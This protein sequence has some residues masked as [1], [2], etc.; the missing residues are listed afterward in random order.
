[1]DS[2]AGTWTGT[3]LYMAVRPSPL[4]GR[5]VE[6]TIS[7]LLLIIPVMGYAYRIA[8]G[9]P[10]PITKPERIAGG[11]YTIRS[12]VWSSGLTLLTFA[13]GRFPYPDD[14][15]GIIELV[16]FLQ[17][18]EPPKLMDEEPCEDGS[19]GVRWSQAMKDFI[20]MW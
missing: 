12:D 4:A 17:R 14:L 3:S 16:S 8:V 13:Q 10:P 11:L 2:I 6:L 18:T 9:L 19:G 20:A 5:A 1:V 7:F 15:D